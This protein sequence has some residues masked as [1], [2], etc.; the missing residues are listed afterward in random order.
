LPSLLLLFEPSLNANLVLVFYVIQYFGVMTYP[1]IIEVY[2]EVTGKIRAIR[3]SFDIF[4]SGGTAQ[5]LTIAAIRTEF[6]T[7]ETA[8]TIYFLW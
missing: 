3:A 8:F 1:V 4:F 2:D 6:A 5:N 7:A